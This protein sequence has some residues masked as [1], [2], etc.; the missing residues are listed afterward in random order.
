[1]VP[2]KLR[3]AAPAP[4]TPALQVVDG[5]AALLRRPSR[6]LPLLKSLVRILPAGLPTWIYTSLLKPRPLRRWANGLLL[7]MIPASVDING[8]TVVLN[9]ADPVVS[10][11]LALGVYESFEAEL[12]ARLA[13]PGSC[14]LDI[15]ANVGYYTA[16]LA[17]AVGPDGS[18][19]AF[20]PE[21]G[22][23][24]VL[25]QTVRANGFGNV[26]TVRGAVSESPGESFLFLSEQNGGD[27]RLYATDGREKITVPIL[28]ID[29]FL[30]AE[31]TVGFIKMDVQGSEGLALRGMR[32]TLRRSPDAQ[33]L[34]EFWPEG[35]MRADTDPAELLATLQE[36]LGFDLWEVDEAK[37]A[38]T[39]ITDTKA[40]IANNPGRRYT[41]LY[42]VRGGDTP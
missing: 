9:A 1:M 34:M 3:P 30:P 31:Q 24:G 32:E 39:P 38:L 42:C 18:V 10:S 15:G 27:H 22:N 28:S 37:R 12:I 17:R 4:V 20:E 21:P 11:A 19:T 29:T 6:L 7:R 33:I 41:N 8:V 16:L 35:L 36:D 25:G 2:L 40:L 26:Q 23:F 14:V 13:Q 5:G